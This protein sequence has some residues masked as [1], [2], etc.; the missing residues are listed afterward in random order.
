MSSDKFLTPDK[1]NEFSYSKKH[2][3]NLFT[4]NNYYIKLFGKRIN[5]EY[6]DLNIEFFFL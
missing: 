6:C 1:F 4:E 2:Y 3:L 5:P